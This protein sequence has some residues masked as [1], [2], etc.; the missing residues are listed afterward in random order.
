MPKYG[1]AAVRALAI[2]RGGVASPRDAWNDAV[3][4]IFLGSKSSQE[5]GCPRD[6]FLGLC[7]EGLVCDVPHGKYTR[8][9]DNKRYA[10]DAVNI[11][12]NGPCLA[13]DIT[14]LWNK[15][16]GGQIKAHNG[17]M[18]VVVALW[19]NGDITPPL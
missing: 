8:S 11:L 14:T 6:A 17:Q 16:L 7:E 1:K 12:R 13:K 5:K 18:D 2:Y 9:K 3:E 15:V 19:Q 10:V 4:K